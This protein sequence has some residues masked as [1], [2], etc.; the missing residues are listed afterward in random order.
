MGWPAEGVFV[1]G[2]NSDQTLR[3]GIRAY[4]IR[5]NRF[6]GG[7]GG[8]LVRNIHADAQ[9]MHGLLFIGN[10]VDT[11]HRMFQ[12]GTNETVFSGNTIIHSFALNPV[13]DISGGDNIRIAGN[14]IYG[15][16]VK[17]VKQDLLTVDGLCWNIAFRTN[18]LKDLCL[19]KGHPEVIPR[20]VVQVASPSPA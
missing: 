20:H 10:C 6:H 12:G 14:M 7:R 16:H 19:D 5:D 13:F 17:R 18:L 9:Y 15:N 4:I 11:N 8:Y 3:S 2:S 1:P